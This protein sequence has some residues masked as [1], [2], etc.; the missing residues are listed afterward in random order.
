MLLQELL[1]YIVVYLLINILYR[2]LLVKRSEC[3]EEEATCR[4][5]RRCV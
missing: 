5:V 3:G 1:A 4:E 2:E